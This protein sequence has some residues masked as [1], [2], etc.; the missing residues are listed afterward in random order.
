MDIEKDMALHNL[1]TVMGL[2]WGIRQILR[3]VEG[4]LATFALPC[5]S[6]IFMSS[7]QHQRTLEKPW[8]NLSFPFVHTGNLLSTR[9]SL[10]WALAMCR[11][12]VTLI[13]N[14]HRSKLVF[15]PFIE[16]FRSFMEL[17]IFEVKWSLSLGAKKSVLILGMCC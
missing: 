7:S 5:N 14:P 11:S 2:L 16:H 15:H 4:E 17:G 6:W 8:G 9:G 12:V 1:A 10:L 13:E 3:V